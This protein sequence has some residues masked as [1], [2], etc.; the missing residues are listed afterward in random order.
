MLLL[1]LAS[2][3]WA[4]D[5]YFKAEDWWQLWVIN[6][7][8]LNHLIFR[9]DLFANH[10]A[11]TYQQIFFSKFFDFNPY[12]W[13]ILGYFLKVVNSLAVALMVLG[14]TKSKRAAFYAGLIFAASVGGLE[15]YIWLAGQTSA[16]ILLPMALG[17]YFWVRSFSNKLLSKNYILALF[18]FLLAIFGDPGRGSVILVLALL[19]DAL[20]LIQNRSRKNFL[21]VISR[22]TLFIFICLFLLL[23]F[24]KEHVFTST[25]SNYKEW[26][27]YLINNPIKTT[28]NFL[29]SLGNFI[30][31]GFIFTYD[32]GHMSHPSIQALVSG[33]FFTIILFLFLINSFTRENIFLKQM[34]FFCL[35]V[36]VA[37]FPS[38]FVTH[39]FYGPPLIAGVT[40]RYFT[41][42]AVGLSAALGLLLTK[43]KKPTAII[44]LITIVISNISQ[45]SRILKQ[46]WNYRSTTIIKPIWDKIDREI[47]IGETN[48]IILFLGGDPIVN[49]LDSADAIPYA[50][51]RGITNPEDIPIQTIV[52]KEPLEK[53]LC[54]DGAGYITA[55]R[56]QALA[57]KRIPLSHLHV[58]EVKY[59]IITNVSG[60]E[61][62]RLASELKCNYI[63]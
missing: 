50:L 54:E 51:K 15:S 36:M 46:E 27:N 48:D 37:F 6:N 17:F 23:V 16:L 19:W 34:L 22:N 30:S 31:G 60:R 55:V 24:W 61:R 21:K 42:S 57:K 56:E 20:V 9:T 29:T 11:S 1:S 8:H 63:L 62:K 7:P 3:F 13:K 4:F 18:L 59:G 44:L 5:F 53:L 43:F 25:T 10:P 45:A 38:W 58:W 2:F 47:P 39:Y 12:F 40:H 33:A 52:G 41:I 28:Q 14:I 35:W 49:E 32:S 26:T